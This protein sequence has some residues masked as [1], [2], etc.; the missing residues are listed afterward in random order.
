MAPHPQAAAT[1]SPPATP[2]GLVGAV[3]AGGAAPV[4]ASF[5]VGSGGGGGFMWGGGLCLSLTSIWRILEMSVGL[6]GLGPWTT[7][8]DGLLAWSFFPL[9][10]IVGTSLGMSSAIDFQ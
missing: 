5:S 4:L 7:T 9:F 2:A 8:T 6:P 1:A 10:C 3:A